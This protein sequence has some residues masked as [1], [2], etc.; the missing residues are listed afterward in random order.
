MPTASFAPA[1][2][3]APMQMVAAAPVQ[4]MAAPQMV[5]AAPVQAV[6]APL[7]FST[8]LS[9]P[10]AAPAFTFSLRP[11]AALQQDTLSAD[12]L[13]T[14]LRAVQDRKQKAA[15]A[16]AR[17]TDDCCEE[18]RGKIADLDAKVSKLGDEVSIHSAV[19]FDVLKKHPDL[20]EKYRAELG[21]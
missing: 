17:M 21:K 20:L 13:E 14:M 2:A 11:S 15:A 10:A 4:M 18:L 19:M 8:V 9:A 3:A 12:D 7:Q 16:P 6:Q 1:F 5:A